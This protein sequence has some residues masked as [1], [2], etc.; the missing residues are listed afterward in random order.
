[1]V[2]KCQPVLNLMRKITG[3]RWGADKTTLMLIYRAFIRSRIDYGS[4]AYRLQTTS[5]RN[6]T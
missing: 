4:I 3:Q 2:K 5:C 1:M 6:W